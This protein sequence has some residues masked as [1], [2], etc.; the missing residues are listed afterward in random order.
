MFE[1]KSLILLFLEMFVALQIFWSCEKA[2]LA[3]YIWLPGRLASPHT[4]NGKDFSKTIEEIDKHLI[5]FDPERNE[6]GEKS[7]KSA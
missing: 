4:L 5:M 6:D 1:L 3:Y 2:V 7:C